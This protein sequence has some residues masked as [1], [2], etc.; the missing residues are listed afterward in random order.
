MIFFN[1]SLLNLDI[2][3]FKYDKHSFYLYFG[4]DLKNEQE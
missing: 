2:Y 1:A 3:E 4:I